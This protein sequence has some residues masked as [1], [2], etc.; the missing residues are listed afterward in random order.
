MVEVYSDR[1]DIVSPG[2]VCKGINRDNFG[3]ISISR[4]PNIA[5]MLLRIGY[6]EQ[7]GTGIMRMKAAAKEAKV[8][9]PE[10]ELDNFFRVSFKRTLE[11][12][13]SGRQST[14]TSDWQAIGIL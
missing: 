2:G 10:F 14:E 9:E 7:M 3:K 6:I 1:V 13:S 4:N 12:A 8:A 11:D 5:S